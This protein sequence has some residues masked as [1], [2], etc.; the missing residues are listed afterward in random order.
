MTVD[1]VADE[2][3]DFLKRNELYVDVSYVGT[4]T[5]LVDIEWGDWKHEHLRC[6]YLIKEFCKMY[7]LI[8]KRIETMVTE[9]DG[10]DCYSGT[11]YFT[12]EPQYK[13]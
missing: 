8:C 11:H 3:Y 6:D 10:S 1:F 5:V 12:Y 9:D 7:H 2:L 13:L 4:D